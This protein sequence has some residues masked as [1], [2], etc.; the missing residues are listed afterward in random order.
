MPARD[1]ILHIGYELRSLQETRNGLTA[2]LSLAGSPCNAYGLDI[3]DLTLEVDY[4][5]DTRYIFGLYKAGEAL[6]CLVDYMSTFTTLHESNSP[7]LS[8]CLRCPHLTATSTKIRLAS[9]STTSRHHSLSG[10]LAVLSQMQHLCLTR[11]Y[12][13]CPRHRY[14][15]SCMRMRRSTIIRPP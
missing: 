7:F 12:P 13:H 5:S 9:S 6:N 8:R 10:L 11:G 3:P 1:L 15:L 2:R 4:D 14:H